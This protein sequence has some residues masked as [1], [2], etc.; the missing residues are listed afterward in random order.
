MKYKIK[1]ILCLILLSLFIMPNVYA[2]SIKVNEITVKDKSGTITIDDLEL[3]DDGTITSNITFNQI[4]DFVTFD[5]EIENNYNTPYA[6][7]SITNNKNDYL[8]V[9]Y[10]YGKIIQSGSKEHFNVTIKYNEELI[11]HDDIIYNN[12]SLRLNFSNDQA[13]INPQTGNPIQLFIKVL[14][15]FGLL[16]LGTIIIKKRKIKYCILL[17]LLIPFLTKAEEGNIISLNFSNVKV[18]ARFLQYEVVIDLGNGEYQ[19]VNETYGTTIEELPEPEKRGY[20]FVKWIDQDNHDVS[21][22]T[23]I[24]GDMQLTPVYEPIQYTITYNLDG[25]TVSVSNP[26]TY[27]I[28]TNSFTLNN[29]TKPGYTFAGWRD[30]DSGEVQTSVTIQQG[31]I[32]DKTYT[33]TFSPR[34]DTAYTVIHK[35]Q[36]LN[37]NDYTTYETQNLT[38]ATDS[39]VTPQRRTYTGFTSPA[40]QTVTISGDGTT[41]VTY[42]YARNTYTFSVSDRTYVSGTSNGTYKYGY[43]ISVTAQSRAGYTFKWSDNTTSLTKSF[44]I[45]SN[46]TLSAV[47]TARTDTAYKVIHQQQN[48]DDNNYTTVSTL[49]YTGT[50]GASITPA[51]NSYTGF[52]SPSTQTKTINGDGSTTITYQYNRISYTLTLNNSQYITTSTPSGSYRYG[53]S[54]TLTAKTREGCT[55]IK[56]SD[57]TT[58]STYTFTMTGNKTIGPVYEQ[59]KYLVTLNP[60]GGSV[61]PTTKL[62]EIGSNVGELPTPER[63]GCDFLGWYSSLLTGGVE[64]TSSYVPTGDVEIYAKWD[65]NFVDFDYTGSVQTYTIPK[66]GRY[67]LEVWGAQGGNYYNSGKTGNKPGLGGYSKGEVYL[68]SSNIIYVY[69]GGAGGNATFSSQGIAGF[70][71]G[72]TI[73][74]SYTGRNAGAGGGGSDIRVGT[75]S[76][77]ARIIV[78]GGGG[79]ASPTNNTTVRQLG[80]AGGGA[81]GEK[82]FYESYTSGYPCDGYPGTQ[83][84][85]GSKSSYYNSDTI[86]ATSGGFGVGGSGAYKNTSW[87]CASGGGGWYGGGGTNYT[88]GAGGGSGW[89]YTASTFTYWASNS[90]EGQ[91]G[92]WLLDDSYY[93]SNASTIA[94]NTSFTAPDGTSE[95]GHSGNGY[96]RITYLGS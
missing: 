18:K 60:N 32:N 94:G 30:G 21:E 75:D 39:S 63:E 44:T 83:I 12:L 37:D 72:G 82:G 54:I 4:Y 84:N 1:Y 5:V 13:L 15:G 47:Y 25:G 74:G 55:F 14:L 33:A 29:P 31:T 77:Y 7:E 6:L 95:T 79:G 43:S 10:E 53:K 70:N 51:V 52:T 92:N 36:N 80:G 86:E 11:N 40:G 9:E 38:G 76:L 17:M 24:E 8:S 85:G 27:N 62:V 90:T 66:S 50:T 46:T 59:Y 3:D 68:N 22:D 20:S 96:A 41:T 67:K 93:L 34:N 23:I 73:P 61:S 64:I 42:L 89:I 71:G 57:D 69:V 56:W 26:V 16:Y 49:N 28:E 2:S 45:S 91:S 81:S 58:T 78:A 19:T 35:Q 87:S 48:I 88:G 65:T